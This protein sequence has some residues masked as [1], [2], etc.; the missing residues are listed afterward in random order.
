[1]PHC[2]LP[3]SL[4]HSAHF[5][6]CPLWIVLSVVSFNSPCWLHSRTPSLCE[7]PLRADNPPM[8][9]YIPATKT[10]TF[11]KLKVLP[12]RK[13]QPVSLSDVVVLVRTGL[14][15]PLQGPHLLACSTTDMT[16]STTFF[17]HYRSRLLETSVPKQVSRYSNAFET[18]LRTRPLSATV[19]P[20]SLSRLS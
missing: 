7:T 5:A 16:L 12:Y 2:L 1:M 17:S 4:A 13:G 20:D 8:K 6:L 14:L 10:V 15:G 18:D 3:L 9:S 19:I 11:T